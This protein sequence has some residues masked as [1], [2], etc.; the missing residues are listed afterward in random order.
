LL[1]LIPKTILFFF[2][3]LFATPLIYI[4]ILALMG[5]LEKR[6]LIILNKL[7]YRLGPFSKPFRIMIG[8]LEKFVK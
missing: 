3:S 1:I 4:L 8:F 6:D 2:I 5:A 7:V